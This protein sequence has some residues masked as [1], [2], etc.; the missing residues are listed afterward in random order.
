MD[1]LVPADP[2]NSESCEVPWP[3]GKLVLGHGESDE[4]WISIPYWIIY[5][6]FPIGLYIGIIQ[7]D[8][9]LGLYN[10]DSHSYPN[11]LSSDWRIP[12]NPMGIGFISQMTGDLTGYLGRYLGR[13]W[14][15]SVG[16]YLM[17]EPNGE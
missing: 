4:T 10:W 3:R 17:T 8:Y 16:G 6:N 15:T 7:L 9:I 1:R 13:Y 11:F 5:W 14:E 12:I 2:S